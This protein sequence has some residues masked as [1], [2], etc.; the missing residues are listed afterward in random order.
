[1]AQAIMTTTRVLA[2][3]V[4]VSLLFG[5]AE[6]RPDTDDSRAHSGLQFKTTN[7]SRDGQASI[8]HGTVLNRFDEPVDGIRYVLTVVDPG[9]PKTEVFHWQQQAATMLA[10][11]AQETVALS[12]ENMN[13][14]TR[15]RTRLRI[16]AAPVKLDGRDMP[17]PEGWKN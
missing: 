3:A 9:P 12:V 14:G 17:P 16:V 15:S 6:K 13:F 11:G 10:P 7:V 4:L 2:T 8:F 1:M 5:C